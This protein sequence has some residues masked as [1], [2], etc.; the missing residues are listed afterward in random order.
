MGRAEKTLL[1]ELGSPE[2]RVEEQEIG[3]GI[4]NSCKCFGGPSKYFCDQWES[5]IS[6]ARESLELG[7][8]VRDPF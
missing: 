8:R 5:I 4:N 3:G 2:V 7:Q 6:D 1:K